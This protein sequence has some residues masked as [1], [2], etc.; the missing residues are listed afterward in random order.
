MPINE[1][2]GG[3]G[4]G[5]RSRT[6]RNRHTSNS[7]MKKSDRNVCT[8]ERHDIARAIDADPESVGEVLLSIDASDN[9]ITVEKGEWP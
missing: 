2:F 1:L 9:G 4:H 6:G 7:E 3:V 8:F 5:L